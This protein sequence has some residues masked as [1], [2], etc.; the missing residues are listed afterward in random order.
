MGIS[1]QINGIIMRRKNRLP[2][3]E[4]RLKELEQMRQILSELEY[5][6]EQMIDGK[7]NVKEDGKYA[8]LLAQN[9]EM[10]WKLQGLDLSGCYM[11]VDRA[12][13]AL[14]D[15]RKRFSRECISISVIGEARR[16]K[17]A[18]LKS[19][20]GLN[21]YVIPAFEST[22]C[23]GTPSIIYNK[24]GSSLCAV[25]TFKSRRQM[26]DMA[27]VYLD[28]MISDPSRRI[29]LDSMQDI[30]NLDMEDVLSRASKGDANGIYRKYLSKMVNHYDDWAKY[31]G[32]EET[33]PL[34]DEKQI[35]SFVAQNN[36][37]PVGEAG[38]EE[39][40]KYLVVEKCE[41]TCNFPMQDT[42]KINLVDTVGLG[43]HTI[44]I[45]ESM[46]LTVK[47]KSDAVVFLIMPQ[48]GAGGGIPQSVTEIYKQIVASCR[49]KELDKWLF[50]LINHVERPNKVYAVNSALCQSAM[51]MLSESGYFGSGNAKIV[52]ALDEEAVRSEFLVPL[53][54]KLAENID[55]IDQIYVDQI[56]KS[57][58]DVGVEYNVLCTKV[59]K[60]LQSDISRNASMIPLLNQLTEESRKNMRAELFGLMNQWREKR[61]QPCPI[62][63]HSASDILERMVQDGRKDSYLPQLDE[64]LGQLNTG[65]QPSTLYIRYANQI[66]NAITRDFQDVNIQLKCLVDEMKNQITEVL[67]KKCG[68]FLLYA[69][70]ERQP[71]YE[72]LHGFS[73]HVLG[74]DGVYENIKLAVD[75]LYSFEFSVKGFLTYEVR[76]CMDDLDPELSD[77]PSLVSKKG[78][79]KNTAGNIRMMLLQ[80]LCDIADALERVMK[81]IC[82]KPNRALFAEVIE[83]YDRMIYAEGV[84]M[85]WNNFYAEKA[86]ILWSD[87]IKKVQNVGIL[88]QDWIDMAEGMQKLNHNL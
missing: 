15:G 81:E 23:T 19:I 28:K 22:D 47:E 9:P 53:L 4:G 73:A 11:A 68:F 87:K 61:A 48:N 63:F 33:L 24:E 8:E 77:I 57:L 50:Y 71:I 35:A 2:M 51:Q 49:E 76:N 46:L 62:L 70:D 5:M 20:S 84:D 30:K 10:A 78:S 14:E 80:R 55:S 41:I 59:Q 18:L 82:I 36:G 29:R 37:V 42:G 45:L 25:L 40:Y 56:D 65:V 32:S 74:E 58:K 75:T 21:D 38:R 69:R 16:G 3:V 79:L 43:D 67:C 60:V 12:E 85:E 86:A 72:W 26:L 34:Y 7:G 88:C 6:R 44:G 64:I 27:Q 13:E 54:E 1:E 17:S 39:Y 83:F 31:A 52:N 66:R